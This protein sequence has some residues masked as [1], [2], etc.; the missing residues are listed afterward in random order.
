M[1]IND[2][3]DIHSQDEWRAMGVCQS[4]G[5]VHYAIHIP[6]PEVM[7]FR[8]PRQ[9]R[10]PSVKQQQQQS[11]APHDGQEKEKKSDPQG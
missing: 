6:E 10:N 3:N 9:D 1:K 8:R 4:L 11:Q 7:L 2:V 5:W